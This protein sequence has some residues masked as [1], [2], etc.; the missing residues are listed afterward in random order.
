[1]TL[2]TKTIEH[3]FAFNSASVA[4]AVA[5]TFTASTVF[6][7]E[8]SS[9]TI[10]SAILE[11]SVFDN[12]AAAASIT[13]VNTSVQIDAVGAS[14]ATVTLTITNS[15]ENQSFVF[16]K[17]VTA[18]FVTNFTGTSHSVTP[19]ITVTGNATCNAS[20]KLIL[21]YEYN[22][23]AATTR[24][25]TVKIPIDGNT[26]NLT[27]TAT[28]LGG[29]ATQIPNLSTFLPEASKVFRNIFFEWT[30]HTGTTAAAA[31]VL[32]INYNGTT[33][34]DLSHAA[35]LIT[36]VF[37]RR[38]DDVTGI[39]NTGATNALQASSTSATGKPCPCLCGVLVVT[40]EY[41]HS[42]STSIIN[43]VQIPVMDESGWIGGTA[44][45]DKSRFTRELNVQ[46][47]G[48]ITLVQSGVMVTCIDAGAITIDLRMGAQASRTFA[49]ATTVRAGSVSLMRRIDSGAVG[50]AGITL[51]HGYN[52]LV[53]DWFSTSATAGNIGSNVSGLLYLN[54]TSGKHTDGDGVHNHTTAWIIHPYATGG[55]V[56]RQQITPARTPI[57][58]ETEYWLASVGYN[59]QLM[60]S[61]TAAGSLGFAMQFEVDAAEAEGGGWRAA[62]NAIYA[63]DAEI[64]PSQMFARARSEYRR[65]PNDSDDTRLNVE[66]ARSYRFDCNV[67]AAA[68]WQAYM[69]L[70]YH[71][72]N[73]PIA[74]TISG[75]AGGT[76]TITANRISDGL[77]V[78]STSRVGDGTFTM[79]WYDDTENVIVRAYEDDTHKGV[80]ISQP[81]AVANVFDISLA[82]GGGGGGGPTYYSY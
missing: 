75:S 71:S 22:D 82:A 47:P 24:V 74:G 12:Q 3:G 25:K 8:N 10:R 14:A 19:A 6:V 13:A 31:A 53:M 49:H 27:T 33:V 77:R 45:A 9:R 39:I 35:T 21:T 26:G 54:Y 34:G 4:T 32:N 68:V 1:M 70:S 80:S 17:D 40:Y 16:L 79:P 55:L 73:Y 42:A 7:P 78:G 61:G 63:S 60:T 30:T 5:R 15:G 65:W 2:R 62:Y 81:A 41:D 43:S 64:G 51:T 58:P 76:V 52:N 48:T 11:F 38:L 23:A 29:V 67:T 28:N 57:V 20:C 18:Y 36:D 69:L 66:T 50:G 46:E 72:I 56:Q 44:T 59:I 37:Y